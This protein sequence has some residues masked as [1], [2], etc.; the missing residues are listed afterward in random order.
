MDMKSVKRLGVLLAAV[1]AIALVFGCAST[2][3]VGKDGKIQLESEVSVTTLEHKGTGVGLNPPAWFTV[4]FDK[5][6]AGLQAMDEH[7]DEYCFVGFATMS[8]QTAA[9]TWA[10]NFSVQQQI[11]QMI[12]T[13]VASLFKANESMVPDN[14]DARRA[15]DNA[16]NTLSI[17]EYSGAQPQG[18]WWIKQRHGAVAG[19]DE[20]IDYTA[21]VF[22]TLKKADLDEQ[23]RTQ[24]NRLKDGNPA[25][26]AAFD[27]V[28]TD[29]LNQGTEWT[30][31]KN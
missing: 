25:L 11:G 27:A 12:S 2:P 9:T 7:K 19:Q 20:Y 14:D 26:V 16:I 13:G 1:A 15:Y 4:Y 31:A 5:Q 22:Y 24:L 23:I 18:D 21:Y 28:A 30:V 29:V 17:A 3:K 10:T 8:G 6:I